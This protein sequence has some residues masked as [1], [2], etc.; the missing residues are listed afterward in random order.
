[1]RG[2]TW[3]GLGGDAGLDDDLG[4]DAVRAEQ[5][6]AAA[7]DA[8]DALVDRAALFVR[9][10]TAAAELEEREREVAQREL[11]VHEN[12]QR[13]EALTRWEQALE[14]VAVAQAA[15]SGEL[16]D[17]EAELAAVAAALAQREQRFASRWRWLIRT[18]R[19]RPRITRARS[20][21]CDLL[22]VSNGDG[23]T[24]L[25]QHGVALEVGARV[26]GILGAGNA[27]VVTKIAP[28]AFDGR[29]CAYLQAE[30]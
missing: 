21:S 29:W 24:L 9:L 10:E 2:L 11:V 4:G 7:R 8:L 28:W 20:R 16:D 6:V 3:L 18:W 30:R 27:F 23:Y 12:E 17:R 26:T 19:R 5:L 25:E 1:M 14:E 13:A 22:F 15:I